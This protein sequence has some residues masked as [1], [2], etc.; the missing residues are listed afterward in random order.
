MNKIDSQVIVDIIRKRTGAKNALTQYQVAEEYYIETGEEI[1]P[2]TVR[3]IIGELRF[4]G[5]PILSSPH[6]P[7]G[8]F[9]P[10]SRREYFD[11][12]AREMAKAKKQI[13]KIEPVGIGVY[14]MFHRT[15]IQ[16][17]WDFGKKMLRV[18]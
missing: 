16:Q 13:A 17:A 7:G 2:R 4:A 5:L 18:S 8:Y 11:W 14:R 3:R 9:Y 12:K 1:E 15:A 10:A 6:E